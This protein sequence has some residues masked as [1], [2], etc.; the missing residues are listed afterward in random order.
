MLSKEVP[1]TGKKRKIQELIKLPIYFSDFSLQ[2]SKESV[3][4]G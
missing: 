4:F 3:H 1:Q 2:L